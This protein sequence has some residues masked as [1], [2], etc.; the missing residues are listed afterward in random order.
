MGQAGVSLMIRIKGTAPIAKDLH[1]LAELLESQ[2]LQNKIGLAAQRIIRKNTREGKDFEGKPFPTAKDP[3][4]NSPYSKGHAR[5]RRR[6]QGAGK[7]LQ[8]IRKDLHFSEHGGMM[9]K[10]DH[11]VSGD[12]RSV[13]LFIDD[14]EKSKIAGFLMAGAGKNKMKHRFFELSEESART[15]SALAGEEIGRFLRLA[16]LSDTP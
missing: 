14:P 3:A 5:K 15:I 6:G 2:Q 1:Q 11:V 8:T 9:E 10:L 7:A 4:E 16:N 12:L 13:T